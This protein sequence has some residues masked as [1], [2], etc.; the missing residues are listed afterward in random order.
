MGRLLAVSTLRAASPM[1]TDSHD[2]A[3]DTMASTP[4]TANHSITPASGRN[5]TSS[6]TATTNVSP[7]IVCTT[8]PT[9]W[10]VR[11]DARAI[12]MV[13]NR[14]MMPSV[15]SMATVIAVPWA[16]LA[17]ASTRMPGVR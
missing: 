12:D 6:D 1:A 14:A 2:R 10:P 17:I 7:I 3:K 9:T 8:A 15:M 11:T 4:I 16:A 13:R 5:P